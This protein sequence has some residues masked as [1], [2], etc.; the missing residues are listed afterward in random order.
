MSVHSSTYPGLPLSIA[1]ELESFLHVLIYLAVRFL[2]TGSLNVWAFVDNYFEGFAMNNNNRRTCG[3]LKKEIIRTGSLMWDEVPIRF[4]SA[5]PPAAGPRGVQQQDEAAL[6]S[7]LNDVIEN[8]LAFFKARYAVLEYERQVMKAQP[9][10]LHSLESAIEAATPSTAAAERSKQMRLALDRAMG[11]PVRS[12][13]VQKPA[14]RSDSKGPTKPAQSVYEMAANLKTHEAILDML[15]T[16]IRMRLW[17]SKD[18]VGDQLTGYVPSQLQST[19]K[20][21]RHEMRSSMQSIPE[22]EALHSGHS[23]A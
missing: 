22:G 13:G 9:R 10:P 1:D 15:F 21:A 12:T 5:P 4:L 3:L 17:P 2:R 23:A 11:L 18:F 7:P 20:R 8:Y 14:P 6:L 19:A 16:E